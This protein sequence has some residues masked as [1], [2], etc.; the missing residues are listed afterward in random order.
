M[1]A[2]PRSLMLILFVHLLLVPAMAAEDPWGIVAA[3]TNKDGNGYER[4]VAAEKAWFMKRVVEPYLATAKPGGTDDAAVR[5]LLTQTA[6]VHCRMYL[7]VLLGTTQAIERLRPLADAGDDKSGDP[8]L[9]YAAW[10]QGVL[11]GWDWGDTNRWN[12]RCRN[13]WR[14]D[15]AGWNAKYPLSLMIEIDNHCLNT[16][17]NVDDPKAKNAGH[18]YGSRLAVSYEKAWAADEFTGRERALVALCRE[19][20]LQSAGAEVYIPRVLALVK[21]RND[22]IGHMVRGE[23]AI[24]QAWVARGTGWANTVTAEG[25]KT[26][27]ERLRYAEEQLTAAWKLDPSLPESA[28]SLAKITFQTRDKATA[29]SWFKRAITA[30]FAHPTAYDV[31]LTFLMP[32]WYGSSEELAVFGS[33]CQDTKRYDTPVPFMLL[34]CLVNNRND[35]RDTFAKTYGTQPWK[36]RLEAL[37]R[38]YEQ[39]QGKDSAFAG[40]VRTEQACFLMSVG[41]HKRGLDVLG[42]VPPHVRAWNRLKTWGLNRDEIATQLTAPTPPNF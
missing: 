20:S 12:N 28:A 2:Q 7:G 4:F 38:G 34:H 26:F 21:D 33:A 27:D 24:I 41:D 25:Q 1:S 40:R 42:S 37:A 30:E 36:D 13:R 23:L 35:Q 16:W 11:A 10:R 18:F 17:N 5:E 9:P 8:L 6:S 29:L 32:R 39:T 19:A 14:A 22:W 15:E 31:M 3:A